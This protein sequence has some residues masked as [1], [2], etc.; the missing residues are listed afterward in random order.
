MKYWILGIAI[1]SVLTGC[2]TTTSST[3]RKQYV[4]GVSQEQLNQLGAQAFVEAKTK[5]PLSTDAKQN[6]YVRCIVNALV[7]QLP[8]ADRSTGWET[9]VVT[10]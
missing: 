8:P 9:A 1:A 2:A 4:G 5:G 10:N 7:L 3:G 6:A